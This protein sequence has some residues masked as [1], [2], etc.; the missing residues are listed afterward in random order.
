MTRRQWLTTET[1]WTLSYPSRQTVALRDWG[2]TYMVSSSDE[3]LS[4]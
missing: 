3:G 4:W 1:F 2:R